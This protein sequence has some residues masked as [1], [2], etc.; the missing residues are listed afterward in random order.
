MKSR[1]SA[2]RSEEL[3]RALQEAGLSGRVRV[4]VPLP[5]TDGAPGSSFQS[6]KA[7]PTPGA[8]EAVPPDRL[9]R[10]L[11][12]SGRG[13]L[14]EVAGQISS[15]RTSLAY[16][17]AA[18]ATTRGELVGWIDLPHALDPGALLRAGADLRSV[19]WVRPPEARSAL[20]SA[21]LLIKTGFALVA[22]DLEG[23]A[24]REIGRMGPPIWSRLLRA[25]REARTTALVLGSTRVTG[26][27][28]TLGLETR[29][30]RARFEHG[31]FEGLDCSAHIERSREG[32][33][34]GELP[35]QT[36]HRAAS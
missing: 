19:L 16:R 21:E 14:I 28:A 24:S 34:P 23:A 36:W 18:G 1:S 13:R 25:V 26:S 6:E 11:A 9:L 7:S 8:E 30:T 35:F 33:P 29:R 17:M 27:F 10:P 22:L 31:L 15:G 3:M 4:G 20:R 12:R 2:K 32:A 5:H